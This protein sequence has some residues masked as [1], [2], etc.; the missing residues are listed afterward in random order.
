LTV[1]I[2]A[3][4]NR[5]QCFYIEGFFLAVSVES[6]IHIGKHAA[7]HN[8]PFF[9][10]LSAPFL[11][12]YYW[13][14]ME[15][16]LPYADGIIGNEHEAA[17]FGRKQ[18]W[19]TDLNVIAEKLS[20][21]PKINTA[22]PRMVIFTQGSRNTLVHINGETTRDFAPIKV[23]VDE[24]ADLNGAGDSFVGGFLSRYVKGRPVEECVAAGHYCACCIIKVSGAVFHGKPSFSFP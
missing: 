13:E 4:V 14:N 19:D 9:L 17:A 23:P 21:W 1:E 3:L 11:I 22:R 24:I 15:Q 8:K 5:A 12:E 6:M 7:D 20:Q 18:G 10:N 16:V 2:Q